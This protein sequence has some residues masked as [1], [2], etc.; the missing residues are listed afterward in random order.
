[1]VTGGESVMEG[2]PEVGVGLRAIGRSCRCG[3]SK[4]YGWYYG[5]CSKNKGR[6][7]NLLWK[8][9]EMESLKKNFG[10]N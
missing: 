8:F 5:E 9:K 7:A 3:W 2:S 6:G 4:G 1:M 10:S